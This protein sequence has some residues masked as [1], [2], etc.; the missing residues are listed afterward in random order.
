[1]LFKPAFLTLSLSAALLAG[2]STTHYIDISPKA[3]V[4]TNTY[5]NNKV[6]EVLTTTKLSKTVGAIDTGIKEHAD[7]L[8]ANDIKESVKASVLEGIK[9]LGFTPEQ[10]LLPAS[11]IAIEISKM[12][13]TTKVETL[14]TV[15]TL[16]FELKVT[17]TAKG[18]IYKANYGSQKVKEYGTMPFRE[19]VEED[20]NELA[21]Q[22]VTRLLN[23][24][25]VVILLKD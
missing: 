6:I 16:D 14:K 5:T 20:M 18:Q 10:G 7:I 13:Y 23:D 17:T 21:S 24:N 8:I 4:K 3:D 1:M 11:T 2:C 15:A 25:N 9:A 22:T 19:T 12:S